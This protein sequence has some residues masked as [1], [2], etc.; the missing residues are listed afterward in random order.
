MT[1]KRQYNSASVTAQ[2]SALANMKMADLW[3]LWD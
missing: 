2:V 1:D 3:L